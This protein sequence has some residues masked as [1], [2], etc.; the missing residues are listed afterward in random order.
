M[1]S[2]NRVC[3]QLLPLRSSEPFTLVGHGKEQLPVTNHMLDADGK[4][5]PET[6]SWNTSLARYTLIEEAFRNGTSMQD[7]ARALSVPQTAH[8]LHLAYEQK[9][10]ALPSAAAAAV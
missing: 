5:M 6:D 2:T 9:S 7:L 1:D 3:V 10:A 8:M 4:R